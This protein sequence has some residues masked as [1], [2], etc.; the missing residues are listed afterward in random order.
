M[1][2]GPSNPRIISST[3]SLGTFSVISMVLGLAGTVIL[4]R[5]FSAAEF[6]VFTL[7]LVLVSFLSQ[8]SVFGLDLS[9]SKFIASTQDEPSKERYL[10]TAAIVRI[11]IVLLASLLAWLGIP[12]LQIIFGE[13][14]LPGFIIFVLPLFALE[15]L[16]GLLKSTLQGCLLFSRIGIADLIFSL[17]NF[18]LLV[19]IVY[20]IN[21]DITYLIGAR[22][23]SSFLACVYSFIA[24]PIKKR[25]FF[26]F[27]TFNELI[28]FGLPLQLNGILNFI[29]S[30]IDTIVIAAFLGPA[31]I[32]LYEVA[33][34]I[35]DYLRNLFEPFVSVYYPFFGKRYALE[36]QQQASRLLNDAIRF[37]A[38]S[39]IFGAVIAVSFGHD[40]IRLLFSEKYM[41]SAPIFAILMINQSIVLSGNL[42]GYSLVAV[43]D[44]D[45]PVIINT[46]NAIVSWLGSV[47]LVP[48]YALFGAAV[49]NALGTLVAFPLNRHFLRRRI[50]LMDILYLKPFILFFFWSVLVFLINPQ[51]L[52]VKFAFLVVFLLASVFLSIIKKD[53]IV[54]LLEGSGA[55][56][57][58]PLKKLVIWVS[59]S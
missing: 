37:V 10:S 54:I 36:G 21:G 31:E 16:R 55:S 40:I 1:I 44:S 58:L 35:P 14:L 48:A 6:G 12:L 3:V 11:G 24:I 30:R 41:A 46:F 5:Q 52:L 23:F 13:S 17:I 53:D 2:S 15:S 34:K 26:D 4:T 56:A 18:A 29:Y 59:K 7:I 9:V 38:F 32:A 43:G 19:V 50:K 20:L 39:T 28:K 47:L 45:K 57:W 25:I 51:L 22:I 27:T 33:R 49:A 42:L 8:M